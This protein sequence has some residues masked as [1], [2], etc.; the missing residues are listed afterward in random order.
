MNNVKAKMC[1]R[2]LF[3]GMQ[4][5]F[6]SIGMN[7]ATFVRFKNVLAKISAKYRQNITRFSQP[8]KIYIPLS[9]NL[10]GHLPCSSIIIDS[11]I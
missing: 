7:D 11:S 8:V 4:H 10:L 6:V 5:Y 3:A 1:V 2:F 9:V